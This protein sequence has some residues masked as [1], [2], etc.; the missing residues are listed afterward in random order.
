MPR[1]RRRRPYRSTIRRSH[2]R[3]G[4]RAGAVK[5]ARRDQFIDELA[6]WARNKESAD[7]VRFHDFVT[8]MITGTIG[9]NTG[10]L[11][12]TRQLIFS[13]QQLNDQALPMRTAYQL[14]K[15]MNME[16]YCEIEP[17]SPPTNIQMALATQRYR[18]NLPG[19]SEAFDPTDAK[20]QPGCTVK[21]FNFGTAATTG[22]SVG[23][24]PVMVHKVWRPYYY[25][26]IVSSTGGLTPGAATSMWLDCAS[27]DV[28][29]RG[30]LITINRTSILTAIENFTL[31]YYW[32]V[33]VGFKSARFQT[34]QPQTLKIA[35]EQFRAN[36]PARP[37]PLGYESRPY[38]LQ[39]YYA[40]EAKKELIDPTL[41]PKVL[42]RQNLIQEGEDPTDCDTP[43]N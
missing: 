33:R 17:A 28:N 6:G 25:A 34:V 4:R 11:Y 12:E 7:Q 16:L 1:G 9:I 5:I 30:V 40:E 38:L 43:D 31:R 24:I 42:N 8:P 39:Q 15:V 35:H 2:K 3:S 13:L 41:N 29:W 20:L 32:K 26:E 21:S 14:Y 18:S 22:T 27:A 23:P 37:L 19:T 10:Q 36:F